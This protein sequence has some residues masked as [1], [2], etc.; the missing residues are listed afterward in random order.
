MRHLTSFLLLAMLAISCQMR[1][2]YPAHEGF[3]QAGNAKI[4]YES[5]G[6]GN[7]EMPVILLHAGFLDA[8]MWKGQVQ[9]LSKHFPVVAIDIPGHGRTENDTIRLLPADFIKA[10][11]DSLKI[12]KASVIGVSFGGACATDFIIA[13]PERVN[14]AVL[15][16]PGLNGWE[17]KFPL[18]S[19]LN[20]YITSFFGTLEKKDT[21][22]AAE[23][24]TRTWFDGPYRTP[25]Q[26]NDTLRRYIYETTLGN[27]QKHHVRGWPIF[28]EPPAIENISKINLPVLIIHGDKDMPSIDSITAYLEKNIRGARRMVIAGTGHMLNMEAPGQF[29]KA[30]IDFLK[31]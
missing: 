26:V 12:P 2:P 10:V 19:L 25:Q 5:G 13:H 21:V 11:M 22:A 14:K 6:S 29:N 23:I 28:A 24:F 30:V 31:Q 20:N 16:A 27:M 4:Y 9:E 17:R 18:D 8:N 15:V 1:I 7:N 3:I